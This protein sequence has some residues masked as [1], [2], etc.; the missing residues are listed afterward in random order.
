M[1]VSI[2]W[3][4]ETQHV[5][6]QRYEGKWTWEDFNHASQETRTLAD[7]VPDNVLLFIDMSQASQMPQGNVLSY[8]RSAFNTMPN[9]MTNIIVALQSHIIEVFA[10]VVIKM[11][12]HW[13]NRVHFTKTLAEGQQLVAEIIAKNKV[14]N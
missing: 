6:F 14:G 4:D 3:Y 11:L 13:R 2:G 9:N 10:D 8:G 7:S 12:P 5:I 1:P